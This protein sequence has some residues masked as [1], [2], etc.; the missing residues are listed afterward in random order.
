MATQLDIY[1]IALSYLGVMPLTSPTDDTQKSGKLCIANYESCRDYVL[2]EHPWKCC[3]KRAFL[4]PLYSPPD[5]PTGVNTARVPLS[6]PNTLTSWQYACQLP[7]DYIGLVVND[8][9]KIC[10][11]IEGKQL[12]TNEQTIFIRYVWR[13]TPDFFD[14]HLAEII[15]LYMAKRMAMGLIQNTQVVGAMSKEYLSCLSKAKFHD[16]RMVKPIT[17]NEYFYENARMQANHI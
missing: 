5:P 9:S 15:G 3:I 2:R 8:D 10:F 7:A 4:T 6:D 17:Q 14:P 1:N 16:A 12:L 13:A 11:L